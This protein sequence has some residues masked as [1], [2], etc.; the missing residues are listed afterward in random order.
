MANPWGMIAYG[1]LKSAGTEMQVAGIRKA[2]QATVKGY[3]EAMRSALFAADMTA[4]GGKYEA[5]RDELMTQRIMGQ[6][7]NAYGVAG[8]ETTTGAALDMTTDSLRELKL[9]K[10]VKEYT[11]RQE[12][13]NMRQQ[14]DYYRR[15]ARNTKSAG[16]LQE[17]SARISG[18]SDMVSGGMMMGGGK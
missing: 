1:A 11:A 6:Q 2:T 14:A 18:L 7:E 17:W 3:K 15:A 8:V 5:W 4:E 9:E 13:S 12:S 16:K 10:L